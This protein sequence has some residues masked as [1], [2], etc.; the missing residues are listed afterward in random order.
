MLQSGG[1]DRCPKAPIQLLLEAAC[2]WD[3]CYSFEAP[4]ADGGR[5][6]RKSLCIF[7]ALEARGHDAYL[8]P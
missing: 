1:R 6:F 7:F 8:T 4:D 2:T 3:R 5:A